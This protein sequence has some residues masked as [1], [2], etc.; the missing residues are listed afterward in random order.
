MKY[1]DIKSSLDQIDDVFLLTFNENSREFFLRDILLH[2][3]I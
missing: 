1:F 2:Y 3:I